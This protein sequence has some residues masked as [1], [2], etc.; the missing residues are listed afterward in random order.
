MISAS[1]GLILFERAEMRGRRG[2]RRSKGA[3]ID[4]AREGWVR[5]SR[6]HFDTFHAG[7]HV[8]SRGAGQCDIRQHRRLIET[9]SFMSGCGRRL[10]V[11]EDTKVRRAARV[12]RADLT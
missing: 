9:L 1:K 7:K 8:A 4:S 10:M 2:L 12:A 6:A 3:S 5:G 11:R